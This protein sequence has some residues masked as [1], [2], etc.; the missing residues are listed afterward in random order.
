MK[1]QLLNIILSLSIC[2]PLMTSLSLAEDLYISDKLLVP[3]RKGQGN[4]FA[5]LHKGLPSGTRV[6]LIERD[7]SWTKIRTNGGITGWV[8][9]QYLLENPTASVS[10]VSV[11]EDLAAAQALNK[12]V[13]AENNKLSLDLKETKEALNTALQTSSNTNNELATLKEISGSAIQSYEQVQTLAK[14]I[15]LLQTE[16][17]VLIAEKER[18]EQSERT[19]FFLY[20]ALAVLLGVLI[21]VIL[22]KL[23]VSKRNDGWAN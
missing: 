19:R 20:G 15:Q 6:T 18:L 23:R 10:I 7:E 1:K 13:R 8:R 17:D 3:V 4:Q 22:P 11:R 12:Q 21:A 14:E 2:S 16:N 9:N 5:I